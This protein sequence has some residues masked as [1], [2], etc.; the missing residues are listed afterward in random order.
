M[1]DFE[2]LCKKAAK[3]AIEADSITTSTFQRKLGIGYRTAVMIMEVLENN[4]IVSPVINGIRTPMISD[5]SKIELHIPA[6]FI[7]QIE[8]P[9]ERKVETKNLA[10]FDEYGAD[11]FF[12]LDKKQLLLRRVTL[13]FINGCMISPNYLVNALR[14]G[15]GL[16]SRLMLALMDLGIVGYKDGKFCL[17]IT[18]IAEFDA[19]ILRQ[20]EIKANTPLELRAAR[21]AV[22]CNGTRGAILQEYFGIGYTRANELMNYLVDHKVVSTDSH[23]D[24]N[25]ILFAKTA[26]EY[27]N[28]P[29][30]GA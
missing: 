10:K 17:K 2:N 30:V 28:N 29:P 20:E 7:K 21:L 23:P 24:R 3:L 11:I 27:L 12:N 15:S 4:Q 16:A 18:D 8:T 19:A 6:E 26:E 5:A 13:R 14:C 25:R 9:T 22:I 1:E